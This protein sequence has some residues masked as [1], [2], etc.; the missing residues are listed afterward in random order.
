MPTE[1]LPEIV[2]TRANIYWDDLQA[3][4]L[5]DLWRRSER[6]YYGLDEFGGWKDSVAVTF[7]GADGENVLARF[8]H[9]RSIGQ[10]I[11]AMAGQERP[12]FVA[13]AV[14]DKT[15]S[16]AEAP[17]ATGLIQNFWSEWDLEAKTAQDDEH[18][19][20]YGVGFLHMRWSIHAGKKLPA[21][22]LP[23]GTQ[24]PPKREGDVIAE[25]LPPWRVIHDPRNTVEMPWCIAAHEESIWDLAARYPQMAEAILAARGTQVTCWPK[26]LWGEPWQTRD[27]TDEMV[28]VWCLYHIP[29]DALP[30]GR[31]AIIMGDLCLYDG[32][33]ILD[34]EVP[35]RPMV[36]ARQM[37][38]GTGY[39]A[40]WDLLVVQE[41]YDMAE[42]TIATSHE[43]GAV[44]SWTAAR[45]AGVDPADL[46]SNRR[47]IA[48]DADTGLPD[49]GRPQPLEVPSLPS[50]AY[51]YP[52]RLQGKMEVLSGLNSVARGEPDSNL[53][54]GA[55][56]ALVQ[57]LA[58]QFNSR[59]QAA[60]IQH[61][62]AVATLGYRLL[63]RTMVSPRLSRV[64]GQ[65]DAQYLKPV[66]ADELEDVDAVEID[67]GPALMNQAAG[68][69]EIAKDLLE[70]N[71]IKDP[72]QYIQIIATGRIEPLLK[73][74]MA[75]LKLINEE[76]DALL[77]GR[78]PVGEPKTDPMGQPIVG[79]DGQPAMSSA[80]V[81]QDPAQHMREHA[82]LLTATVDPKV[83]AA[84]ERHMADH[85]E[86]FS[87][88]P[89]DLAALM[90][91]SVPPPAP[92]GAPPGPP[93]EGDAAAGDAPG[94]PGPSPPNPDRAR[95]LGAPSSPDQ[96]LMPQNALTGQRAPAGPPI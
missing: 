16:L 24:A 81:S 79:P 35:V 40:L 56:L 82:A 9:Y 76:N 47:L 71:L 72:Q 70:K 65:G 5:I 6:T 68:K 90:G 21:E 59:F 12:S 29:T 66:T 1:Q 32:P 41:L 87:K 45:E 92:M 78:L 75:A 50:Q 88:T 31:Y 14:D 49:G 93:P 55:A 83:A 89:P 91:W 23:D 17:I 7:S 38:R 46:A 48:F 64:A 18:A 15:R 58:V 63:K 43:G 86:I 13:R 11:L 30:N 62:E 42:S 73:S 19:L 33:A 54:S 25:S 57:S 20:V 52:D 39:S 95:P 28:T 84:I 77:D 4:G 44:G 3:Y 96:P 2:R 26:D 69:L 27:Q 8:N 61:R 94:D 80:R 51:E 36:A 10:G 60:R 74:P 22:M 85:Y 34:M 53:K 67:V 37:G